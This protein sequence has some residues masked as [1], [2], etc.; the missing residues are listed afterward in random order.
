MLALPLR[1]E[2]PAKVCPTQGNHADD[3]H[4]CMYAFDS[5]EKYTYDSRE[6]DKLV[7]H[8]IELLLE[9]ETVVAVNNVNVKQ[10]V[11]RGHERNDTPDSSIHHLLYATRF[12]W[13]A[14]THRCHP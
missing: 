14:G 11:M 13:S 8:D 5:P 7:H 2:T 10:T 1:H 3:E 6:A 12:T 4:V 9:S